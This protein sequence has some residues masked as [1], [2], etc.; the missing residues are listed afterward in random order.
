MSKPLR[1]IRILAFVLGGIVALLA[2]VAAVAFMTFD[3]A[4]I[5]DE[6]TRVVLET[7]QRHLKI[8]G[9]LELSLW[10]N[11]GVRLGHA[12]LS[13]RE[14]EDVFLSLERARVSVAVLPLL[15]RQLVIDE[16][17]LAGAN[18]HLVRRK[19]GSFNFD[20]LLS[21]DE[22]QSETVRFAVAG[23]RLSDA[24]AVFEDLQAGRRV[25][26]SQLRLTTG[27]LGN[28]ADGR[29]S[30]FGTVKV[31]QPAVAADVALDGAYRIDL[32]SRDA[33]LGK[34]DLRLKGDVAAL[35]SAVLTLEAERLQARGDTGGLGADG[36]RVGIQGVMGSDNLNASITVPT[37]QLSPQ[38][39]A[40][41]TLQVQAQ[42]EGAARRAD[43]KLSL[44]G[45]E[46]RESAWQ[47]QRLALTL[48]ARQAEAGVKGT[49]AS[50]V[51][52]NLDSS[53]AA[54]PNVAGTLEL[55]HPSMPMK[56][57]K[58]PIEA[59]SSV[60]WAKETAALEL[61]THFDESR[62]QAKLGATKFS[63]LATQF[64]IDIDRL[65][66]D[67]YFPPA[68]PGAAPKGA[69]DE[70][71]RRIDLSA[72]KDLNTSGTLRVGRLQASNLRASD[73]LVQVKAAKGRMDVAPL[74]ANLYEGSTK[75]SLTLNAQGNQV[76]VRQI[77]T[78]VRVDTL[79][80]DL[81]QKEPLEGRGNV[82]VD[83]KTAGATVDAMKRGLNGNAAV[84]LRDGAVKGINLAK[85][86]R[87][88]RAT[89]SMEQEAVQ[90]AS[91][92]EKTDF[93]DL[94]ASFSIKNGVA[95]NKDLLAR[96]PLLRVT[97]AGAIDIGG[98]TIDYLAKASVVG[99]S[100][101]QDGKELAQLKGVTVPVKLTGPF[102]NISYRVDA[103]SL[104]SSA[105][106]AKVQ[107]K[108]QQ[109]AEEQFKDKLKGLLPR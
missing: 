70:A 10:P 68:K 58:L 24:A 52:V 5:K 78:G 101:G 57:L 72:L 80:F 41:K 94:K 102:D 27:R 4:R 67:K 89:F 23:V 37:L 91:A 103:A 88:I 11:I 14:A 12:T 2:V 95:H 77:L 16:V 26:L 28:E 39:I 98:S 49:L 6:L 34:V 40:L 42:L 55:A 38:A 104:V 75:G 93:S 87:Q 84:A 90:R 29:L 74:S 46:G 97:G 79:M 50:P 15:S 108:I 51:T 13:E 30:L 76:A 9:E 32:E 44:D 21:K 33:T 48:D 56:T 36:L 19:D 35:K 7:K 22:E 69:G 109:K 64:D 31:D 106:K 92:D 105:A 60:N 81:M 96:S 66:V 54:L 100:T 45:V 17:E 73:V 65:N 3:S 85:T 99:T 47:A 18:V 61:Q 8:D 83:V 82:T 25:E 62:V 53:E 107:E 86:F 20:D 1:L 59:K 43:V 71:A 63:P